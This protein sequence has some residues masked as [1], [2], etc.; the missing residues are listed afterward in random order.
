MAE[1]LPAD[2]QAAKEAIDHLL[3][4]LCRWRTE[5]FHGKVTLHIEDGVATRYVEEKS[6][7]IPIT[8]RA[9][10]RAGAL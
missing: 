2:E 7:K 5:R 3:V 6:V 4:C 9:V 8:P 10:R 1:P